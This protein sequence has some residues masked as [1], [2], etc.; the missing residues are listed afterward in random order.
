MTDA[1]FADSRTGRPHALL[2]EYV[3]SYVGYDLRRFPPGD[4]AGL[5]SRHLTF[6][7]Q[8]DA[9]LE[10]AVLPDGARTP[11]RFDA[12]VSGLHTTPVVIRH[13]GDQRGIQLRVT[14]AGAR[15]LF[16]MPAGELVAAA[17]P[18]DTLWAGIAGE[19]LDRLQSAATWDER[20]ATLDRVLLRAAAGRAE[21]PSAVRPETAQAWRRLVAAQGCV[22]IGTLAAT[23]G[24]SRRHLSDQ[25]GAEYGVTPKEMARVL[26]FERSKRLFVRPQRPTL[27][28]IAA[29]CG[30]AD[31]AHMAREWR[32]LAGASPTQWRAN[33]ALPVVPAD[34]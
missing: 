29:E 24:W 32:A 13:D 1:P 25:F 23:V 27:A 4:H 14:P 19:L 30:Y 20:F 3:D 15:A 8:F 5:P 9:P 26:R 17:V 31:Q 33:E 7:I 34:A 2:R 12:V 28:V 18:L 16:G 10:L 22:D 11:Q 6:V 21:V